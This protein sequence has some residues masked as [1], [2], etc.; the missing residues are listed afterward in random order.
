MLY[1]FLLFSFIRNTRVCIRLRPVRSNHQSH[2]ST[3][4]HYRRF[5]AMLVWTYS[6]RDPRAW[7]PLG[8]LCWQPALRFAYGLQVLWCSHED[9]A[10][11]LACQQTDAPTQQWSWETGKHYV[12]ISW[13]VRICYWMT[14]ST[15][16]KCSWFLIKFCMGESFGYFIECLLSHIQWALSDLH[17][18]MFMSR[19]WERRW[20]WSVNV[21]VYPAPAP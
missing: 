5:A 12:T 7:L 10:L 13:K 9:E 15:F 2:H 20:W 21:M 16:G 14:N 6:C 1:E 17:V 18:F 11:R 4:V 19:C 8:R 3:G